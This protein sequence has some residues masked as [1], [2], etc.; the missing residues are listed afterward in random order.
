M[1]AFNTNEKPSTQ[2]LQDLQDNWT[3]DDIENAKNQL[4]G[5]VHEDVDVADTGLADTEFAVAHTLGIIPSGFATKNS[6]KAGI[7]YDSGGTAWTDTNI[8]LKNNVA[9]CAVTIRVLV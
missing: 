9:N 8:Y 7:N 1:T 5:L 2:T 4:A 6:D 3:L